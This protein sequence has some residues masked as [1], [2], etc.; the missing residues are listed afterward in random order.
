MAHLRTYPGFIPPRFIPWTDRAGRFN[1]LKALAFIGV[2]LPAIVLIWNYEAGALGARKLNQAIH[3]TGLWSLRFLAISLLITPLRVIFNQNRF[4]GIRRILGVA[5]AAYIAA[6]LV[7]YA[8]DEAWDLGK[9]VSEIVLRFYLTIGFVAMVSLFIMAA[10]STDAMIA[11]LG[12]RWKRLHKLAFLVVV[13]GTWH[14]YL[15]SKANVGEAVL[16]SGLFLWLLV[17]RFFPARLQR[18]PAV[19]LGL[20]ILAGPATAGLE[21]AWYGFATRIPVNRIFPAN[22]N[23]VYGLRPAHWL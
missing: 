6:H 20:G 3:I 17:W 15:Q 22:W 4:V 8:A 12:R 21:A 19:L 5:S 2:L 11:R 1:A 23:F 14:M 16:M 13:L 10:T 7:L 18:A 9:V